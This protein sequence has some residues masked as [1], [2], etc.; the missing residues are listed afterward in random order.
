MQRTGILKVSNGVSQLKNWRRLARE[1]EEFPLET[2]TDFLAERGFDDE[3][4]ISV[5]GTLGSLDDGTAVCFITEA[6]TA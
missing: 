5:T 1:G 2:A 4:P 6:Q 3:D